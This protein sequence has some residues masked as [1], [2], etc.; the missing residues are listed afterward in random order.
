MKFMVGKTG[1]WLWLTMATAAAAFSAGQD[2]DLSEKGERLMNGSCTA[3]HDIRTIQTAAHDEEG[4][5]KIVHAM[6]EKGAKVNKDDIPLLVGYLVDTQGPLPEGPG[7]SIVLQKCTMCH[8]LSRVRRHY[9][10]PE[11]WADTLS[12]MFNEGLSLT[13]EEFAT[14]L[15]YLARNF[16]Q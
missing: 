16:R 4:W 13:D 8:T 5:T 15:R 6:I 7:K 14:V 10:T 11:G 3:C 9:T 1:V 12:A 2:V